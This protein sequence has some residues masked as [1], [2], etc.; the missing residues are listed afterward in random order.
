MGLDLA[1]SSA[2]WAGENPTAKW[3]ARHGGDYEA[4]EAFLRRSQR[5]EAAR[6]LAEKKRQLRERNLLRI[7][8]A[9][10]T[11]SLVIVGSLGMFAYSLKDENARDLTRIEQEKNHAALELA[12]AG[13]AAFEAGNLTDAYRERVSLLGLPEAER[14][15]PAVDFAIQRLGSLSLTTVHPPSGAP[16]ISLVAGPSGQV[17]VQD[18]RGDVYQ[19]DPV[20]NLLN[21]RSAPIGR[22]LFTKQESGKVVGYTSSGARGSVGGPAVSAALANWSS[23][24]LTSLADAPAG[25]IS[26]EAVQRALPLLAAPGQDPVAQVI[27]DSRSNWL[28]ARSAG[29]VA[30]VI[31]LTASEPVMT[32]AANL[33]A[34][35][36][37]AP[38]PPRLAACLSQEGGL[39][40]LGVGGNGQIVAQPTS[41][42]FSH[43]Y[44]VGPVIVAERSDGQLLVL[45]PGDG[46]T[47]MSLGVFRTDLQQPLALSPS[48][49]ILPFRGGQILSLEIQ[50]NDVAVAGAGLSVA[51]PSGIEAAALV[52][53][54]RTLLLLDSVGAV[55][56]LD[57]SALW[58][59]DDPPGGTPSPAGPAATN[60]ATMTLRLLPGVPSGSS[61]AMLG[62]RGPL[63][64]VRRYGDGEVVATIRGR[65]WLLPEFS[66][67]VAASTGQ[68]QT[69]ARDERLRAPDEALLAEFA[70]L[71]PDT[72]LPLVT[73]KQGSD[74]ELAQC[75]TGLVAVGFGGGLFAENGQR[76]SLA[77]W[78]YSHLPNLFAENAS[79][80][81]M[82]VE[83][84]E[85][86]VRLIHLRTGREISAPFG[87]LLGAQ[88]L[89]FED[90]LLVERARDRSASI[91]LP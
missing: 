74:L 7:G 54:P 33:G 16:G 19:F 45:N 26:T 63:A 75:G 23:Q 36:V 11:V 57:L 9:G 70:Q 85:G 30:N 22:L 24:P 43:V 12:D 5:E 68:A 29:G 8:V 35:G 20:R 87:A 47:E 62:S 1:V 59:Q 4:T 76:V 15:Q 40:W 52:G 14:A 55:K 67:G 31:D 51:I 72:Q 44:N 81:E 2:W 34:S 46:R 83:D 49:W 32:V 86:H 38:A 53:S 82:A 17:F 48:V 89:Q 25:P 80:P 78:R 65:Y 6:D 69:G 77:G 10:L 73:S 18:S 91:R 41:G 58:F 50:P 28:L 56:S 66:R 79:R 71:T 60:A 27:V 37:C 3:A 13:L 88:S 21:R 42:K 90:G 64:A 61:V 39:V 84:P